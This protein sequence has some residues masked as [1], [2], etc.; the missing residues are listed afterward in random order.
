MN[1]IKT[2]KQRISILESKVDRLVNIAT[3]SSQMVQEYEHK[4]VFC[5]CGN[6]ITDMDIKCGTPNCK[7]GLD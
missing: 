4:A 5:H 7:H 3:V 1:K 2:L 6:N